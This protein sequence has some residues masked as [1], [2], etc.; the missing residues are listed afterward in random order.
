MKKL[1][2]Y[3]GG[4]IHNLKPADFTHEALEKLINTYARLY[5]AL[6]GF[7]YLA[8][9]DKHGNEEAMNHDIQVWE[10]LAA[11]EINKISRAFNITGNNVESLMK[12]F[13]LTPWAWNIKSEYEMISPN[14]CIWKVR[15]C[16]TV[17]ALEREGK[18]REDEQCNNIE[19]R[20][21]EAYARAVNPDMKVTRLTT[22]PRKNKTDYYCTW[23]FKLE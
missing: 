6:D 16:P 23:E 2:D 11:Y 15:H 3:S 21:N 19:V 8:V 13:Q 10:K 5:K 20:I 4:L 17:D 12:A 7:W 1:D 14:H 22:P 9:M 18:G